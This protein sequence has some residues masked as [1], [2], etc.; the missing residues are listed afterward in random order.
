M[1]E[2]P[3]SFDKI[4]ANTICK[5]TSKEC[6]VQTSG[7][8]KKHVT[9]V[10]STTADGKML[11][12]MNIFKGTTEK[13]IQKLRVPEGFVIKTQEKAWMNEQLMH[14]WVKDV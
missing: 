5:T 7:C 10:L 1:D 11:P 12:P 13:T 4:P 2:T 3:A 9:I 6:V 14:V 8:K